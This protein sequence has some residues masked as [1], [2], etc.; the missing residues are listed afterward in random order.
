MTCKSEK[1]FHLSEK[2]FTAGFSPIPFQEEYD[3]NTEWV[4]PNNIDDTH[5]MINCLTSILQSDDLKQ[6][7]VLSRNVYIRLKLVPLK[8]FKSEFCY[9][10]CQSR[11]VRKLV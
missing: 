4:T 5:T 11:Q 3:V 9:R 8:C 2:N 10:C 1:N 7:G 6:N